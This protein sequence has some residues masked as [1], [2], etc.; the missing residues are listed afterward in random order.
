MFRGHEAVGEIYFQPPR[1]NLGYDLHFQKDHAITQGNHPIPSN[2]LA[3]YPE[4][5]L[6]Q[7]MMGSW[8]V[9][10]NVEKFGWEGV[11]QFE[12]GGMTTSTCNVA[13]DPCKLPWSES[14]GGSDIETNQGGS[15]SMK[16]NIIIIQSYNHSEFECISSI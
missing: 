5:Q 7:V 13:L 16:L 8:E 3:A 15:L 2:R 10:V 12:W 6:P 14:K 11:P 4:K 1:L 9:G